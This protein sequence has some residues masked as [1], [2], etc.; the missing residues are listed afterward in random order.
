MK[1]LITIEAVT[2]P[3][4]GFWMKTAY[5]IPTGRFPI[6]E[7]FLSQ[8]TDA[9]EPITEMVVNSLI[10]SPADGEQVR[11]GQ[12]VE[13]AGSAWDAGYGVRRVE[14]P[15]DGGD[16]WQA[17]ELG[18]ELG[19]FAFR[20]WNYHF[21]PRTPEKLTISARA[22]NAIGQTPAGSLIFTSRA[23]TTMSSGR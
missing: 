1:H 21:T 17:A 22:S 20:S 11:V 12:P 15:V 8:M 18:P 9:N 10:A 2:K 4:G 16:V 19:R 23:I 14:V 3:F 13:I 5:R 7:H 6:V